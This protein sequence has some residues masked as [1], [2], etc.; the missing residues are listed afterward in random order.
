[1]K[2][3]IPFDFPAW[4][5]AA[6]VTLTFSAGAATVWVLFELDWTYQLGIAQGSGS[7][8]DWWAAIAGV[9]A[10]IGTWA[11]GAGAVYFAYRSHVL[12]VES[13]GQK[14]DQE[15]AIRLRDEA[16]RTN[17]LWVALTACTGAVGIKSQLERF[18]ALP[19]SQHT[20]GFLR[21]LLDV[22]A[23]SS[24]PIEL[25]KDVVAVIPTT[26]I[27]TRRFL[28]SNLSRV[29]AVVANLS[30]VAAGRP[31]GDLLS[32]AEMRAVKDLCVSAASVDALARAF[33]KQIRG[34][35]GMD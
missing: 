17:L 32:G 14:R 34:A 15:K 30:H 2:G 16:I 33:G 11:I 5:I 9:F 6:A 19:P 3:R 4:W 26:A 21:D 18:I 7:V 27:Q 1:M 22:L 25:D 29:R 23:I 10:A 31:A 12:S 24:A 8:A 28:N 35:L 13:E 20:F